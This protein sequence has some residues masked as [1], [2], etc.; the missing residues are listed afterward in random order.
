MAYD[1]MRRYLITKH[2]NLNISFVDTVH[3]AF[4]EGEELDPTPIELVNTVPL[5]IIP[6]V[7]IFPNEVPVKPI[8]TPTTNQ[9]NE[10]ALVNTK[11]FS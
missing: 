9:I 4:I 10:V 11:P 8:V 3:K 6:L 1:D 7:D 2:L 5:S